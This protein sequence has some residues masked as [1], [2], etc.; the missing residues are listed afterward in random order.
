[1]AFCHNDATFHRCPQ[2][3]T[4]RKSP[5]KQNVQIPSRTSQGPILLLVKELTC[6]FFA[7][8]NQIPSPLWLLPMKL[9]TAA[10]INQSDSNLVRLLF[11]QV[12]EFRV[13]CAGAGH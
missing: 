2:V 7:L 9:W 6:T 1:M 4:G 12:R 11:F 13:H 10:D 3:W 5:V 8:R